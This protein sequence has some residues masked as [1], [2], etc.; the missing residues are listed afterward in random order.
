VPRLIGGRL[1]R[2]RLP[3]AP[4][5][6]GF[7][8]VTPCLRSK[9]Q[10]FCGVIGIWMWRTPRCHIASTIALAIAGGAPTVGDSPTPLAPIGWW[11]DGVIVLPSS[12]LGD[13]TA[14]GPR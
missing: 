1:Y 4:G 14:V 2:V 9:R 7:Y 5:T 10:T 11:G 3:V 8:S 6:W 13:S 12:H